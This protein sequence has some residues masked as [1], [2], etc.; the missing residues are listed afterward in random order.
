MFTSKMT[1]AA[2]FWQRY[3]VCRGTGAMIYRNSNFIRA[4]G[5]WGL[6]AASVAALVAS[7]AAA[8]LPVKAPPPAPTWDGFYLGGSIGWERTDTNWT[9]TCFTSTGFCGPGNPFFVDGSS[10]QNFSGS[11]ARYGAYFG[12]NW[13][14][15][16]TWVVG[17]EADAAFFDQSSRVTGLVG[18]AT[19]CGFRPGVTSDSTTFETTW[20][21]SIRARAGFL[22]TPN[23][24]LYGTG[25]LA[26]Q[27]SNATA[28]C[29]GATSPWCANDRAQTFTS[30]VQPGWTAGGGIEWRAWDNWF[31]RGEY[32]YSGYQSWSPAFF[33]GTADEF[34][35]TLSSHSQM[36]IFGVSYLFGG[37]PVR[38]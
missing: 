24:L 8:D 38:N 29:I 34:H 11:S 31:V 3:L 23:V 37:T 28:T 1:L 33:Q 19:F 26:L 21:S 17:V 27:M 36:A 14:V 13:Q 15:A 6:I 7:A 30:R 10:P 25:G 12:L 35:A 4:V 16:P 22:V 18:C 5:R 32:R 9:T 20:D 2:L